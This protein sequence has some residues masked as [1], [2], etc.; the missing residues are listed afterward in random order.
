MVVL[1]RDRGWPLAE[2]GFFRVAVADHLVLSSR[3]MDF[4][5]SSRVCADEAAHHHRVLCFTRACCTEERGLVFFFPGAAVSRSNYSLPVRSGLVCQWTMDLEPQVTRS[6][7]RRPLDRSSFCLIKAIRQ[8]IAKFLIARRPTLL[9]S[10]N[11]HE[12]SS[13]VQSVVRGR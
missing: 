10:F 7:S 9:P 4:R 2:W 3:S 5:R 11:S 1:G 6:R 13:P 8:V 12:A